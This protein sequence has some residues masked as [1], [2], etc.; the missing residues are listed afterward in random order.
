M[1]DIMTYY[2]DGAEVT[3][4][5]TQ[6]QRRTP[7]ATFLANG[8][9]LVMN[10]DTAHPNSGDYIYSVFT[11]DGVA[12]GVTATL[13]DYEVFTLADGNAITVKEAEGAG[14]PVTLSL[15]DTDPRD[16]T[17]SGTITVPTPSPSATYTGTSVLA[18]TGADQGK[19]AVVSNVDFG[20]SAA[21]AVVNIVDLA[22]MSVV[23]RFTASSSDRDLPPS[24][25]Q[26]ADGSLLTL[27]L[28]NG[29]S[30]G[31]VGYTYAIH[32]VDGTEIK[33]ATLL[34]LPTRY[35]NAVEVQIVAL[36]TGGFAMT[37]A[38]NHS[39]GGFVSLGA[40]HMQVFD[41]SGAV[42]QADT[43]VSEDGPRFVGSTDVVA[44]A[45]GGFAIAW[46]STNPAG[47]ANGASEIALRT[48]DHA[49]GEIGQEQVVNTTTAGTQDA[50]Q[51]LALAD[52]G[53][54]V[55]WR[56]GNGT[57]HSQTYTDHHGQTV[58]G[59]A[60]ADKLV[61]TE[62]DD[63]FLGHGGN[64]R[65]A[66]GAGNDTISFA[67][68]QQGIYLTLATTKPV[69][70]I[71]AGTVQIKSIE[72]AIG[73]Q[74]DDVIL[75]NKDANR[76]EG[77][78]GNDRL[79]G[80][81]GDDHLFGGAGNDAL[82]GQAGADRM[83]GGTGNEVYYVD[84]AGDRVVERGDDAG[85]DK[86]FSTISYRLDANVERL[87]LVSGAG[88]IN[89]AG[90]NANNTIVGNEGDNVLSGGGGIDSLTGGAG[91]DTF[92][93]DT[94]PLAVGRTVI[95]DFVSGEDKI[96]LSL[97][98]FGAG[99]YAQPP[100]AIADAEFG[101]GTR[102]TTAEQSLIYDRASGNLYY[103]VDGNGPEKAVRIGVLMGA[104]DLHLADIILV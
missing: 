48:Y 10:E 33:A 70:T 96:A 78:A 64:D 55:L 34:A 71:G 88:N 11:A 103:D 26:L 49:G 16:G 5:Q 102:A 45:N 41:S 62:K 32:A 17:I 6:A 89:G 63:L 24:V 1:G 44:L 3:L 67:D 54:A 95:R 50:A 35:G 90:N 40:L 91:H 46:A 60:A 47:G 36:A 8:N 13:R 28:D 25:T 20:G 52:G 39:S 9:I 12:S 99:F 19:V 59:T 56:D 66:G 61:G 2:R 14:S 18:L 83:E 15:L 82:F 43:I 4:D 77:G 22:T 104:P 100:G 75:G 73:T 57:L 93:F 58:E 27:A 79:K 65:F 85:I 30:S 98:A 53:F 31:N 87:T 42:V 81:A 101:Y 38:E 21:R 72:N 29:V 86:V 23:A 92:V 80:G 97:D 68:A 76:L 69:D 94:S 51:L 7:F 37:W 84:D 74:F